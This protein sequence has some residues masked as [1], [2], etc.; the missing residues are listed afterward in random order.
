MTIRL[1]ILLMLQLINFAAQYTNTKVGYVAPKSLKFN[2]L[3]CVYSD[4]Y[5]LLLTLLAKHTEEFLYTKYFEFIKYKII[6]STAKLLY[7]NGAK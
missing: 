5:N 2:V 6:T 3:F 7:M 1:K 4:Y